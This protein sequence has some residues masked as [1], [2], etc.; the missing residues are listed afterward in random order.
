ME[1]KIYKL[2]DSRQHVSFAEL[3][4][5]EG[6]EGDL[7]ISFKGNIVLWA[8]LSDEFCDAFDSLKSNGKIRPVPC[9]SFIYLIDGTQLKMK[10]AKGIGPYKTP[11][12]LPVCFVSDKYKGPL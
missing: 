9:G 8:G 3:G 6:A 7:E 11:R 4:R 2:V 5:I 10:V 1:E 12:W